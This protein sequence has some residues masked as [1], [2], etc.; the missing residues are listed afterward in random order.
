MYDPL[1]YIIKK[2]GYICVCSMYVCI[3]KYNFLSTFWRSMIQKAFDFCWRRD[4]VISFLEGQVELLWKH[5]SKKSKN[6]HA[7]KRLKKID[8]VV[9]NHL[10][11]YTNQI[12]IDKIICI[13]RVCGLCLMV[14]SYFH[15]VNF[16]FGSVVN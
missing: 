16:S 14:R 4:V 15:L 1:A 8:L 10:W 13:Y 9:K 12:I 6:S 2:T 7:E 11:K 3:W 5:R